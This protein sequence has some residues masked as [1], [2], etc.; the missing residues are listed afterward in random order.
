[1]G[2]ESLRCNRTGEQAVAMISLIEESARRGSSIVKQVLTF[3]RG[4]EGER[5]LINPR[6]LID[7][8]V[9]IAKR[10]FPKTIEV[11]GKYPEHPWAISCDP[12]Q[13]HQVLLNLSMNARDAMAN[14]GSLI[15]AAKNVEVDANLAATM[16]GAKAGSYATL[17][18]SDT[19]VGMPRALVEKIFEPFFTTKDPGKGTGLGLSTSLGIVKSHAGFISVS[20]EQGRGTTF[21]VFLPAV[22]ADL[23]PCRKE[24]PPV[25]KGNGELVLLVDDE[26]NIRR[27]TKMTLETHNYCVLEANDGPEALA[28]FA[29]HKDSISV[30]LTDLIMPYIDGVALIRALKRIKPD[31]MFIACSGQDAEPRLLELQGLGVVNFLRKPYDTRKLLTVLE[32]AVSKRL[33]PLAKK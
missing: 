30:V 17:R 19:G 12:T 18:V 14:G 31:M 25:A 27:V 4:V 32:S 9:E 3:A 20:T 1:M 7:E 11:T 26:M 22:Q 15:L 24:A 21:T 5:V 29:Q 23:A 33:A 6:H 2:A 10:T 13:L 8:M 16:A 28:I